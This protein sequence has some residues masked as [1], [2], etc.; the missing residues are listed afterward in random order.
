MFADE[1]RKSGAQPLLYMT[2]ST[3]QP[4][5]NEELF[6][7]AAKRARAKLVPAGAAWN[8]LSRSGENLFADAIHPNAAGEQIMTDNIYKALKPMLQK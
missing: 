7:A 2:W 1:V 5:E 4:V 8:E 3:T 6:V